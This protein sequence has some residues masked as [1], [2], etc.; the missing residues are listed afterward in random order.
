MLFNYILLACN[1]RDQ[2]F[3]WIASNVCRALRRLSR[4]FSTIERLNKIFCTI[5]SK[6]TFLFLLKTKYV[7]KK[8][9]ESM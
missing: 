3:F 6:L 2:G 8:P 4:S 7:H 9:D 5:K 1:S